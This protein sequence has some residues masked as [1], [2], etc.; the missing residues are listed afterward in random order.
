MDRPGNRTLLSIALL[1]V[2][3]VSGSAA[4]NASAAGTTAYTCAAGSGAGFSDAH[5]VNAVGSGAAFVHAPITQTT[6][7]TITNAG[8]ANGTTE[9]TSATFKANIQGVEIPFVCTTVSGK[10]SIENVSIGSEMVAFGHAEITFSGCTPELG[11]GCT[12]SGGAVTTEPLT[13]TTAGQ[14]MGVKFAPTG[15][16]TTLVTF[17]VDGCDQPGLNRTYPITGSLVATPNGATLNTTHSGVT[18][19]GTLKML[20]FKAGLSSSLTL[21]GPS[22]AGISF[23]T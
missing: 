9:S 16:G 11:T 1:I 23:T 22:G 12:V 4:A 5:C 10:G 15:P 6:N 13:F 8:T 19:Q 7:I 21:K 20:G 14:E 3:A 17:T 18:V 2:A